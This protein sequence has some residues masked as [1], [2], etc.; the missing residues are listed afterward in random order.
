MTEFKQNC[1]IK[2]LLLNKGGRQPHKLQLP[3]IINKVKNNSNIPHL[4]Y[5]LFFFLYS[6]FFNIFNS[7]TFITALAVDLINSSAVGLHHALAW[8]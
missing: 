8:I 2:I 4:I 1:N 3:P 5:S 6:L 7:P